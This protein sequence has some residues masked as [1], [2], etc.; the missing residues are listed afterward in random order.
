MRGHT[1]GCP[2]GQDVTLKHAG[3]RPS[4]PTPVSRAWSSLWSSL[5]GC[6]LFSDQ[7]GTVLPVSSCCLTMTRL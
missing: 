1:V 4:R 2:D 5:P 7:K 6:F 3:H